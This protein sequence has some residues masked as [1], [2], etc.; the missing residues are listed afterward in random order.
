LFLSDP[1]GITNVYRV[2]VAEG[3]IAQLTN[4][5]SGVSGIT[6]LSP[7][8]T[9]AARDGRT[10][11]TLY[12]N[13]GYELHAMDD[14]AALAGQPPVPAPPGAALLPPARREAG[15]Q[16][17]LNDPARG[18][19]ASAPDSVR[20]YSAGFSL[21]FIAQPSVAV[22]ADRFGTY[23]GGGITLF[24]SDM[25]GNHNLVT[26]AQ[27]NGRLQDFAALVG[28]ENRRSRWNWSVAAQQIPY[29]TGAFGQYFTT[30]QGQ[31]ALVEEVERLRQTNRQLTGVVAYPFNRARRFELAAGVQNISFGHE[32]ERRAVF[33]NGAVA[34]DSTI[35]FPAPDALNLGI[36]SAA[37]VHD[38]SFFGATSPILGDRW[39]LEAS[40]TIGSLTYT[41]ALVDYRRYVMPF[42]P[43]TLAGRVL[44]IGRYGQD[45]DDPRIYPLFIGYPSL[46]RG[47]DI[48]NFSAE[49][50]P[51][52]TVG[53]CPVFDQLL[54]SRMLV[55]NLELRVPPFGLLG[56]GGGYYG[57]IPLELAVFYDA[58]VAWTRAE[59]AQLFGNGP[60][61]IVRSAGVSL[62][63]NLMGWAVGQFDFVRPFDRPAKDWMFRFSLTPGY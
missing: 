37:L 57:A 47:Y 33:Q 49:E 9:V 13:D 25:L 7:A 11:F 5:Y 45:S 56:L 38:N 51:S 35:S 42:R 40:P 26:M 31:T 60:R 54:G 6:P 48:G 30:I 55:A 27:L 18:L 58:G 52:N 12:S 19:P 46:V 59:G 32:L 22:A 44:H 3:T 16:A 62:R 63:L 50:C 39:R 17:L 43:F 1:G 53:A 24:W 28:Y 15:V 34:F 61:Q 23:V 2:T 21:D 36:A 41:T 29:I 10:V 20:P 8:L 4:V 14:P